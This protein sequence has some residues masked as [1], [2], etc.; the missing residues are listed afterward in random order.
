MVYDFATTRAGEFLAN[1]QSPEVPG[2]ATARAIDY[3]LK[4]SGAL[5]RY[6][7][8]GAVH[9]DNNQVENQIRP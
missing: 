3:S 8:D 5:T 9:L 4:R 2:T 6:L 7:D 1:C